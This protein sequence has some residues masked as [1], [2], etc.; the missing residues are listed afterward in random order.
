MYACMKM[1]YKHSILLCEEGNMR[2]GADD[3]GV[4]RGVII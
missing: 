2:A 1:R 3:P 4:R